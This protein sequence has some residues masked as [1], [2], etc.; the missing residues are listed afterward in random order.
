MT[1]EQEQCA[2]IKRGAPP[3]SAEE[4]R[5]LASQA[6]GWSLTDTSLAREFTFQDFREA[7]S[8][9]NRVADIAEREGH[10]PDITIYYN[11]VRL[12]LSTHNI[13]GLSRNDFILAA[14]I[15]KVTGG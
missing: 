14:K 7:I 4:A 2:P 1:L 9:V 10:H 3:M 6:P 5:E 13:G 8:F 15:S 11:K 12:S